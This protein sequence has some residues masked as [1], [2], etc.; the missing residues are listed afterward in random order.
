MMKRF[1]ILLL[2]ICFSVADV[3]AKETFTAHNAIKTTFLS[4]FSGSF[5]IS[6]ERAVLRNQTMEATVGYIGFG[7]DK[8]DNHPKGYTV[9]YAHKFMLFG[10]QRQ[11]LNGFYLR[12]ELIYSRFH[13]DTKESRERKLS[14]MGSALF[15]FGYQYVLQRLV[16]DTFLGSGYAFGN[17]A[18]TNYQHGFALLDYFGAHHKN[19]AITF[20]VKLGVCF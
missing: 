9:R 3:S 15:S 11:A 7:G 14:N 17:E 6:Y 8:F 20:G 10:N 18:D 13:Y 4:W 5:K 12:P 2:G 19:L 1:L 16:I